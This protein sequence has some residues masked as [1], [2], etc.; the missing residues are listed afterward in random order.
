M[1]SGPTNP[2]GGEAVLTL[3]GG[4]IQDEVV[5][6]SIDAIVITDPDL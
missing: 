4:S 5:R 2:V 1:P 3:S 6:Q